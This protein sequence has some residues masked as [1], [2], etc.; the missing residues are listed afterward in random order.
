MVFWHSNREVTK[1]EAGVRAYTIVVPSLTM[2][3]FGGVW[4]FLDQEGS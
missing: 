2:Q 3:I 4:K 1:A